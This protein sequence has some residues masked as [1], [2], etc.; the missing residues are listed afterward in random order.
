MKDD[1]NSSHFSILKQNQELEPPSRAKAGEKKRKQAFR[2]KLPSSFG[3][4]SAAGEKL[5]HESRVGRLEEPLWR[6]KGWRRQACESQLIS[7][8]LMIARG[9]RLG[10]A[11]HGDTAATYAP[12]N[13]SRRPRHRRDAFQTSSSR[14][15]FNVSPPRNR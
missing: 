11:A 8:D 2:E 13:P 10:G 6:L 5:E 7:I 1:F 14:F 3:L 12:F 15:T 9:G 4:V